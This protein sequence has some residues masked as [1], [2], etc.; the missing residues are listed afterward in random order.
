MKRGKKILAAVA[1]T[2]ALVLGASMLTSCST[3]D[4]NLYETTDDN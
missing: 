4:N 2:T 1:V 3:G